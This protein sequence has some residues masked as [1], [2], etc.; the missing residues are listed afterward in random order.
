MSFANLIVLVTGAAQES[1]VALQKLTPIAELSFYLLICN[2]QRASSLCIEFDRQEVSELLGF[3]G[4]V[5]FVYLPRQN[6]YT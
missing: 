3:T 5:S 6:R 2:L 4:E 1:A